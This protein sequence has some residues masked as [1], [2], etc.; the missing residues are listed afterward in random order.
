MT[1]EIP[2]DSLGETESPTPVAL[3]LAG[4]ATGTITGLKRRGFP[5]ALVGALVGGTI[6]YLVGVVSKNAIDI[7]EPP[8]DTDPI[9]IDLADP[10]VTDSA[11][12]QETDATDATD[13]DADAAEGTDSPDGSREEPSSDQ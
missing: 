13:G 5:G 10:T 7:E 1:E 11:D 2:V 6:G 12:D 9:S 8:I 3:S 4:G